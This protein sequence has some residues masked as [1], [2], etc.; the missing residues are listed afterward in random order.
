MQKFFVYLVECS[1]KSLYC[2]STKDIGTRIA[3]H[4]G[5]KASK[6]T[7]A[8]R[9]VKLVFLEAKKSKKAA[10]RREAEIKALN[11]KQKQELVASFSKAKKP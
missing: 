10:L 4:N 8:R 6:Y 9:P 5:G 7:R 11:R 1:D 2:G 3:A